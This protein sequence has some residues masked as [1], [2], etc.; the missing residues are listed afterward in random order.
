MKQQT[1][2]KRFYQ[3]S[4]V[5]IATV[6]GMAICNPTLARPRG[7]GG[8]A[9]RG[10]NAGFRGQPGGGNGGNQISRPSSSNRGQSDRPV[11][12]NSQP[13]GQSNRVQTEPQVGQFQQRVQEIKAS[14]QFQQ[15][16]QEIKA[17]PQFQQRVQEIKASPQFQQRVQEIKASPQFQQR[18]QEIKASPQFQQRVQEIRQNLQTNPETQQ[19]LLDFQQ[20]RQQFK[21]ERREDWQ[22]YLNDTRNERQDK[23]NYNYPYYLNVGYGYDYFWG[24]YYPNYF[25][26]FSALSVNL[27]ANDFDRYNYDSGRYY[28]VPGNDNYSSPGSESARVS[29]LPEGFITVAL[30]SVTYYYY[31]GTFYLR[32]TATD[33]Y[34]VTPA[35]VGAVVPYIPT[36]YQ[37]VIIK[38]VEYYQYAGIYYRPTYIKGQRLYEVVKV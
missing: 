25:V 29:S 11:F 27:F 6:M 26:P 14:P 38:G 36:E 3:F 28:A 30:K 24:G 9:P 35:P 33:N 37:R 15:R 10:D 7:G 13:S 8:F 12:Q 34:T 22:K 21:V 18:V 32:D 19:T 4:S 16:V 2:S 5:A 1:Q 23:R 20:S 31:L 17:S